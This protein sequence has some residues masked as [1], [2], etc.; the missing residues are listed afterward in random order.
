MGFRKSSEIPGRTTVVRHHIDTGNAHPVRQKPYRVT[1]SQ[2]Q[3]IEEKIKRMLD[4]GIIQPSLRPWCSPVVAVANPDGSIRFCL[5]FRG[6]NRVSNYAYP[7]LRIDELLEEIGNKM[8]FSVLDLTKG[9]WQVKLTPESAEKTAKR[10]PDS[11]SSE[12]FLLGLTGHQQPSSVL[13]IR[14]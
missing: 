10:S 5:D 7:L 9:Y 13:W 4:F 11:T 14:F 12:Y 3:A 6:L 2:Q 1:Q 8:V